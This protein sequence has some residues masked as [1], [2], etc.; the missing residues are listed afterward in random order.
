MTLPRGSLRE[1]I[2]V[3]NET[4]PVDRVRLQDSDLWAIT[5]YF[6]PA[7]YE[8][9]RANYRVFREHLNVPLVA[10]ELSFGSDFELSTNDAEILVRLRGGDVMWQKERL[11]N[12]ALNALPRACTKVAWLDCDIV[13]S[14][15]DWAAAAGRLLDKFVLVQ[16]SGRVLLM[17]S[18]WRLGGPSFAAE[19]VRYPPA[20]FVASGVSPEACLADLTPPIH[21]SPG[22]AWVAR[23]ELLDEHGFYDACI[24]GGGDSALACAAYGCLDTAASLHRMTGRRRDHFLSWATSFHR[25]VR[26]SVAFVEGDV[27]HLWHGSR[28]NRRYVE[29]HEGLERFA[30]DPTADIAIGKAGAWEWA[31]DKPNLR[32]FVRGYFAGRKE[33][34]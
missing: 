17:P 24:V 30:F 18:N 4:P 8:R 2:D 20:Y 12:L 14:V 31:S 11:L 3:I 28:E 23:R 21:C 13:F 25:S 22:L 1:R 33:D 32:D 26:S 34:G 19:H 16:P 9:R 10:V 5:V 15:D 29:R 6:N 7:R 27:F